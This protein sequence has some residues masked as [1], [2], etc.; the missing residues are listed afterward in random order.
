MKD[1][2]TWM[3]A[4]PC[5]E[6][7]VVGNNY[8]VIVPDRE[9]PL[10]KNISA[11]SYKVIGEGTFFGGISIDYVRARMPDSN[12]NRAGWYY[13]QLVKLAALLQLPAND[14]DFLVVWDADTLPLINIDFINPE[15]KLRYFRGSEHHSP[16]FA[17]IHR[18]LGMGKIINFSF[19]AQCFPIYRRWIKELID[20]IQSRNGKIWYDAILDNTD[21]GLMSGFSEYETMGTF[22]TH[23]HFSEIEICN[24][25]WE[26]LGAQKYDIREIRDSNTASTGLCY[27]S[28]ESWD[29]PSTKRSL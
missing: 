13:Q 23:R 15:G 22:L 10:F 25:P 11:N 5:I 21:L 19:I 6:R 27:V 17:A 28:F 20:T 1:S 14:D 26:R 2:H 8:H 7:R 29:K 12:K 24:L 18:L 9:V 16:Y 3:F 4:S